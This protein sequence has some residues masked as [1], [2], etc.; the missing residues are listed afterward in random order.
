MRRPWGSPTVAFVQ[1]HRCYRETR[2]AAA[3]K[4]AFLAV[5]DKGSLGLRAALAGTPFG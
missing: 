5:I 2:A 4:A 1:A 3:A